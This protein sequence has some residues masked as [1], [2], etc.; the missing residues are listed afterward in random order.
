MKHQPD[1]DGNFDLAATNLVR[2]L[3]SEMPTF[4]PICPGTYKQCAFPTCGFAAA[5]PPSWL[6]TLHDSA[7]VVRLLM[8]AP[9]RLQ[10]INSRGAFEAAFRNEHTTAPERVAWIAGTIAYKRPG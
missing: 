5:T 4:A 6:R 2:A 3:E 7:H 1:W 10:E 8:L 9:C